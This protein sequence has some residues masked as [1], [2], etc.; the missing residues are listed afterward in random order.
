MMVDRTL[1]HYKI[2]ALLGSGGMGE[3]YRAT[4]TKLG[5]EVALKVLPAELARDPERLA[6]FQREARAAAALN[7]PYLAHWSYMQALLQSR[8]YEEAAAMGERALAISGRHHWALSTM[9]SIYAAWGKPDA[10]LA[11][12]RELEARGAREYVQPSILAEA[13][14]G[15]GEIDQAIAL[16]TRA[17]EERDPLL[18]MIARSWH[19]YDRLRTDARFLEVV[20]RIGFPG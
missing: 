4:D 1:A 6:R 3:V 16:A 14:A 17:L 9:V 15:V 5:R 8:R 20:R 2:T 10:A 19:G 18:V 7:H 13:A 12:W 11:L